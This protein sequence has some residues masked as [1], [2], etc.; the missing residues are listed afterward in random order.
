MSRTAREKV[1]SWCGVEPRSERSS[2][3]RDWAF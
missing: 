1:A 2:S 3:C